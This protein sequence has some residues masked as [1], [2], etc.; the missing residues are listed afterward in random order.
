MTKK[1]KVLNAVAAAALF[2]FI[3]ES[4]A[5]LGVVIKNL[6]ARPQSPGDP[7]SAVPVPGKKVLDA[8]GLAAADAC[9][10]QEKKKVLFVDCNGIYD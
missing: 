6:A 1:N 7:K 4:F 9:V 2:I 10:N 8:R 3:S 5:K